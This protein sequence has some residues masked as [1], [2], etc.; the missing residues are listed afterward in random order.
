MV[1]IAHMRNCLLIIFLFSAGFTFGQNTIG[2]PDI[3]NYEKKTY[4]AGT[5]NWDII[6]DKNGIV[7][8]ANTEGLLSFDGAYWKTYS[9]PNKT[10]GRSMAIGKDNKIYAGSQDDFG[11]FSPDKNGR[12]AFHSLKPLLSE[13]NRNISGIWDI[14]AH[15]NDIFFRSESKIFRYNNGSISIYPAATEWRF[16][17]CSNNQ[18]IAQDLKNGLLKFSNGVWSPFLL[19]STLPSNY[20]VSAI[21]PFGK[22]SSLI[23][24]VKN[25]LFYLTGN[26]VTDFTF[27]GPNPFINELILSCIP[28]NQNW[29]AIGTQLNGC[30]IINKKGAVIQNFSRKEGLQ[31]NCV[32]SLYLDRNRNLWM[33]LDNGVD[34]TAYNNGIKHIYPEHLNEGAGYSSIIY[35]NEFYIGTSNQLYRLPIAGESDLSFKKGNFQPVPDTKGSAWGL[36]NINDKLLMAHH[37]GAYEIKNGSAN[38]INKTAGYWIFVPFYNVLP[39]SLVIAGKYSGLEF[40]NYHNNKLEYKRRLEGFKDAARFAAV[41]DNNMLWIAQYLNGVYKI[42]I[43][44]EVPTKAKLYTDKDGLPSSFGNKLFKIKNRILIATEK[45]IYEY[46]EKKDAFETSEYFKPYFKGKNIRYLIEDASGNIWFVQDKM[47]G[48]IDFSGS[49]PKVIY[50]VELNNKITG[51]FENINPID[52]L[53]ILVGAEKGFYHI[54]YEQYRK[55]SYEI[56]AKIRMV[57][58]FGKEDSLVFG[59]YFGEAND[60]IG[61]SKDARPEVSHNWNSFHFEYSSPLNGHQNSVE[62]SYLLK[63]L[64]DDWSSWSKKTEK[65]YTNLSAGNYT[66]QVK[67]KNYLGNVSAIS[68]FSFIVLPPWYKTPLAYL[69]Y[70]VFVFIFI[71]LLYKRQKKIFVR[72]QQKHEKEQEQLQYLHQLELEKSEKEIIT[73]KNEKLQS[74]IEFKNKELTSVAMHLVQK[75]ELLS[76]IK[77]QLTHLKKENLHDS[78][79]DFKKIIHMMAEENKRDRDWE[80]FALHFDKTHSDFLKA[81]KERYPNL[82]ANELKLCAYLLMNLSSKEIAQLMNISVRGVEISRYRLRKKLTI[83]TEISLF[84]FLMEFSAKQNRVLH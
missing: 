7:Y 78:S 38:T 21:V 72:Q 45:G 42:D 70:M 25:G 57:K 40:Y 29:L 63:G 58:V 84:D 66:F 83:A 31:T 27:S 62:Y 64:D 32:L 14:V 75:G 56:V 69:A 11:Y 35:K 36:Y 77:D 73:L 61:Q 67:A 80:Q 82:S 49:K 9:F 12:L 76:K 6:Q 23:T 4:N 34:F 3:I 13:K 8:F 39:S 60:T 51:T 74:E 28:V 46:N 59:G 22:D 18:V 5:S 53:N 50:F 30:Y 26:K 33:G 65:E 71:Y 54:N 55:N 1:Q 17:G 15:E 20:I 16:L 44:D 41:D 68:S 37:E 81:L 79:S 2:I 47:P 43:N 48:V 19:E 10:M 52:R 24:T